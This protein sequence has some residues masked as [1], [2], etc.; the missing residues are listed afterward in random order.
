VTPSEKTS[1]PR[2]QERDENRELNRQGTK[3]AKK[4]RSKTQREE[5]QYSDKRGIHEPPSVPMCVTKRE[6]QRSF[7]L[8]SERRQSLGKAVMIFLQ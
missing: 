7:Q 5:C 1:P 8:D 6:L 3:N 2:R 4:T